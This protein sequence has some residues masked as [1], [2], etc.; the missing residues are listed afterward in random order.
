MSH[1]VGAAL[2]GAAL[3]LAAMVP[4]TG[5]A[6]AAA[7]MEIWVSPGGNDA[8]DGSAVAPLRTITA[9]WARVPAGAPLTQGVII[10]LAPGEYPRASMPNY[11]ENRHGTDAAGIVIRSGGAARSAVLRGDLNMFNV[12]HLTVQGVVLAPGGDAFHCEQCGHVAIVDSELDGGGAAQEVVKV[13]QSHDIELRGDEIH[14]AWDND[15][16]FV[17]VQHAKVVGN[18]IHGAGDWCAYAKGGSTDIEVRGNEIHSCGTGGF[19]AGQ[20]SGLE[21]LVPPWLT[22]EATDVVVADNF[23]HDT[24]GAA[25]GVN[26]GHNVTIV[27]NWATRVGSRSHLLEVTFGYRS[28]DGNS[29]RCAELLRQGAWGTSVAGG[30][31]SAN[32]PDSGVVIRDNRIVNPPGFSARWQHLEV[33]NPRTNSGSAI[34]P[35]PAR[36]DEGLVITGNVIR[37]GGADMPLGIDDSQVCIPANPTCTGAGIW[38]DND[39]N[40]PTEV[41]V[42]TGLPPASGPAS[43]SPGDVL[44]P[45]DPARVFD[46][47]IAGVGMVSGR[48][49]G[50]TSRTVPVRDGRDIITGAVTRVD[51]VPAGATSVVYN[52]T[53]A[54]TAG[55]GWLTVSRGG[56][57]R[58]FTSVVNWQRGGQESANSMIVDVGVDRTVT[59]HAAGG[60]AEVIIDIVGYFVPADARPSGGGFTPVAPQRAY[61]SRTDL[62]LAPAARPL[63]NGT[64]RTIDT[65][66]AGVPAGALAAAYTVT[67]VDTAGPGYFAVTAGHAPSF[68]A[69]TVNW[70]TSGDIVANG[71]IAPLAVDGSLEVF[72]VGG[73]ADV[74]I[75]IVGYFTAL[76]TTPTA[77][78]F[79]AAGPA[80]T[81]D[82][83]IPVV[84]GGALQG[85]AADR[86]VSVADGRDGFTWALVALDVV[87]ADASAVVFN[88]TV[89]DTRVGAGFLSV[90]PGDASGPPATSTVNWPGPGT[91]RAHGS[92]VVL[93]ADRTI[94]LRTGGPTSAEA[95][96][97][98]VG[99]YA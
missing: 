35:S 72:A 48:M 75:D 70:G 24:E 69:S 22:Y 15:V 30:S 10:T 40:G 20:G 61:D 78:T 64:H 14:G 38:R 23:V 1:G 88:A 16:D 52:L 25:F 96:I 17:A 51:A 31:V 80:R 39:I 90:R 93:G 81:Y 58:P 59:V 68:N 36:T 57:P 60:S 42:P 71:M 27:N 56:A 41:P 32:I 94:S 76:D 82:S 99:Y 8:A 65:R 34:G 92:T 46:S 67:A 5:T 28:C 6:R 97:D 26:G 12:E 91:I 55:T 49:V 62:D 89:D 87:P 4:L 79:H 77:A 9:A 43:S 2:A 3:T 18:L 29:A 44:V 37:N 11:W 7:P 98:V 86:R 45:I 47:R 63:A 83:R 13:N 74:V 53:I 21:F 84:G 19:T 95:I 66:G 33:S 50:G 73:S 54:D 85:G